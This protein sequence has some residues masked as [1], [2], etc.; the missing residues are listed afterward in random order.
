M[1]HALLAAITALAPACASLDHAEIE[2]RLLA[3]DRHAPVR[4]AGGYARLPARVMLRGAPVD[5]EFR[6]LRAGPRGAG[7]PTVVLVHATP[8]SL[9]TWSDV[10]FGGDSF[11]G[12]ARDLDVIALDV[13]G[14]GIT[15]TPLPA[16]GASFALCA[17]WVGAFLDAL[18]LRDVTLVGNSYGGEFAW[19]TALDRPDRVARL[20]LLSSSGFA[21]RDGEW[22]PEE[23]KMREM[24]LAKIGWWISTR[25]RVRG[26]L[27][28]HFAA[29]VSDTHVE[30][31]WLAC[32][33]ADNWGAMI[34]LAR[35]ENGARAAELPRLRQPTLLL[36]GARDLGY[37]LER[38]AR[39][40]AA[41][42]P[43]AR[44]VA[45]PDVGHYP[46][47]EAPAAVAAELRA[48][49]AER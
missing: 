11:A 31:V 7:H 10:V 47:E 6:Y 8:G 45:L 26:A 30:E 38:F 41:A 49:L 17:E 22:L 21:R 44:L 16:E 19:R 24:A 12:L 36:W 18:E 29:P 35:D 39:D 43:H 27:Q 40:F 20:V 48:F 28:P 46:Q 15:E 4:A 32:A 33:N 3:L 37:P 23:V 14:H 25:E 42:L 1:R 2:M 5:A 9:G 34:D 13:I